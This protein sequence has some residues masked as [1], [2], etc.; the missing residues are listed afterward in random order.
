MSLATLIPPQYKLL[1]IGVAAAALVAFSAGATYKV[2]E[3][4]WNSAMADQKSEAATALAKAVADARSDEQAAGKLNYDTEVQHGKDIEARATQLAAALADA[5]RLRDPGR[6]AGSD[7]PQGGSAASPSSGNSAASG[8]ELSP[9][10]GEFLRR[11]ANQCDQVADQFLGCQ[12]YA[13]ELHRI[14]AGAE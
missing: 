11:L 1:A 10:A 8:A 2:E 7:C 3:W 6:R 9:E 13:I 12:K 4:R 14:C 5:R